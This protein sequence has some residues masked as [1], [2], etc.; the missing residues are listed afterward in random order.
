MSG[1]GDGKCSGVMVK[2]FGTAAMNPNSGAKGAC[3]HVTTLKLK[4][5]M[6]LRKSV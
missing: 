2:V 4:L 5:V 3:R 6:E 1:N